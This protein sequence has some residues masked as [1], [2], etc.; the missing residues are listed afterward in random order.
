MISNRT[1]DR[2]TTGSAKLAASVAVLSVAY[3]VSALA[4][5]A[6]LGLMAVVSIDSMIRR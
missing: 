5:A 4:F 3:C 2:I 6:A 1:A